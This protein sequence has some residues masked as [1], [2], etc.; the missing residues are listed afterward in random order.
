MSGGGVEEMY[1]DGKGQLWLLKI[2]KVGSVKR[3]TVT[4]RIKA[5][6]LV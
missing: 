6:F 4:D 5:P 3:I 1:R 2:E